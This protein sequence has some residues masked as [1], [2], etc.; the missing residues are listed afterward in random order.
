MSGCTKFLTRHK[1]LSHKQW[2]QRIEQTPEFNLDT[3]FFG[4]GPA[5]DILQQKMAS[6]LGK[7]QALF[8][9]KGMVAQH[10]ALLQWSSLSACDRIAIHPQSHIQADEELAYKTLFGL[11]AVMFGQE[12]QAIT[13]A[14]IDALP[15]NLATISVELPTRRAGFKLPEWQDLIYLKAFAEKHNIPVHL[16][17]A[18]LLEASCYWSKPYSEVANI[19]DS[20]YVSLYKTLGAAAGGIIAGDKQ[21]IEQLKPWRSRLGG[22]IF[23]VFPYV[24]SALWGLEHYLP[25]IPEFHQ[26]ALAL[27][28]LIKEKIGPEAIPNPVQCNGF[29][30]ELAVDAAVLEEKALL[31]AKDEKIWLFDR[32]FDIGAGSSRFEIQ[33]G[34]ALD[35]WDDGEL[36]ELLI[37]IIG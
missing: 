26:R 28:A 18:R 15:T 35:D 5:I 33:V 31:L 30:V 21:F 27:S 1:P 25:R 37:K 20:V 22:D 34:D 23:T 12:E 32:I 29:V 24:L 8:V 19:G 10:S 4:T 9:H 3:D 6:L 36:V 13:K 2:L 17:G 7:E 16:D 14:D 11:D